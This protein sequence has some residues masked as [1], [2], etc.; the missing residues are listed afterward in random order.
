MERN[1]EN[2]VDLLIE[3]KNDLILQYLEKQSINNLFKL[4]GRPHLSD[5]AKNKIINKNKDFFLSKINTLTPEE[6]Y[7]LLNSYE[8]IEICKKLILESL[9]LNVLRLK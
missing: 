2:V 9:V 5:F 7:E 1:V 4:K 8:T 3:K 6:K